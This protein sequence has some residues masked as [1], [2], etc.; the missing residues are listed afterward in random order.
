MVRSRFVANSRV[1]IVPKL[2]HQYLADRP[3]PAVTSCQ[4]G[5]NCPAQDL[6]DCA[7]L[8]SWPRTG[9]VSAARAIDRA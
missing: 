9:R 2:A 7:L 4:C 6:R 5:T 1:V 3:Y 8:S